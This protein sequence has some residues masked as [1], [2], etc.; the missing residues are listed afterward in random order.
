MG[1]ADVFSGS[2]LIFGKA[3]QDDIE[4]LVEIRCEFL[5]EIGCFDE[6]KQSADK[7]S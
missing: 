2:K 1:K 3:V 6:K 7:R 4:S 5:K